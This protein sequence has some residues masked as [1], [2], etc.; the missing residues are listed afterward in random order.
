MTSLDILIVG[1]AAVFVIGLL[2]ALLDLRNN[3]EP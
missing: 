1:L 3:D 2:L